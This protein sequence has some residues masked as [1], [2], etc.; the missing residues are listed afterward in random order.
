[1]QVKDITAEAGTMVKPA[2]GQILMSDLPEVKDN[3][4]D[5]KAFGVFVRDMK[6]TKSVREFAIETGLSESYVSKAIIGR[7]T[8]QPSKRTLLKL[9]RAQTEV[10]VK[11]RDLAEAAGY[12]TLELE[13]APDEGPET[14]QPLSTAAVITRYYGK[15]HFTAMGEFLKALAEHGLDGDITSRFYREAGY[16][17][18]VDNATGNVYVGINAYLRPLETGEESDGNSDAED[19]DN[20]VFSIAFSVGLNFNRVIVSGGAKDKVVYILTD[21]ERV[22]EGCQTVIPKNK[23]KATVVVLTDDHQGFR[24]EKVLDGSKDDVISLVD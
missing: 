18:V 15:D 7:A 2:G 13:D 1:M 12:E 19:E 10:P 21:N 5:P 16:F 3:G 22:Y 14:S 8:G 20:V 17:E 9:L 4:Y 6:G 24:K 23:T 11:R